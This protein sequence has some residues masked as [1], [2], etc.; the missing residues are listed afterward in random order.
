MDIAKDINHFAKKVYQSSRGSPYALPVTMLPPFAER[1]ADI[2]SFTLPTSPAISPDPVTLIDGRILTGIDQVV[3]CT[4]YHMTVPFLPSLHNDFLAPEQADDKVL[5]TDG[6]QFHNL[7]KDIFYIPDPTLAFV[8]V[9]F[10]TATFTLFEMQ[11]ILVSKIFSG[12]AWMPSQTEM[13][14]EY[15]E[16]LEKKGHGRPFHSLLG[17][18]IPYVAGLVE[19]VNSQIPITGGTKMEGH[20]EAFLLGYKSLPE[21]IKAFEER[22]LASQEKWKAKKEKATNKVAENQKLENQKAKDHE[23]VTQEIEKSTP[24]SQNEVSVQALP[25]QG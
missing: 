9:P 14:K 25:V 24:D 2:A 18:E 22:V 5:V 13:R 16:R 12:Q 1:V 17:I 10:F 3:L 6:T 11:A 4:G 7:H 8:G 23:S 20:T 15:N 21:R 19:W